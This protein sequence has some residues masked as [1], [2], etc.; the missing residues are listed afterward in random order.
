MKNKSKTSAKKTANII[1][2]DRALKVHSK[3]IAKAM[4]LTGMFSLIVAT[5]SCSIEGAYNPNGYAMRCQGRGC[6]KF[7]EYAATLINETRLKDD[8][9]TES[10]FFTNQKARAGKKTW[11]EGLFRP[12]TPSNQGAN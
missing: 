5:T 7:T 1:K 11:I 4:M 10:P 3:K 2:K 9:I 8:E 12:S 6:D